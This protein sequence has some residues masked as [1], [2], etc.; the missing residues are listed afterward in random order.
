MSAGP[1]NFEV[2]VSYDFNSDDL[3]DD[4]SLDIFVPEQDWYWV[5]LKHVA[6]EFP[7]GFVPDAFVGYIGISNMQEN[8]TGKTFMVGYGCPKGKVLFPLLN[9]DNARP[10][11]RIYNKIRLRPDDTMKI[12]Y[13]DKDMVAITPAKLVVTIH[14]SNNPDIIRSC[15]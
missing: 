2:F 10:S 14:I 8:I 13:Y 9:P 7:N 6:I 1:K 5:S 15:I 4:K 12:C 11:S 3:N